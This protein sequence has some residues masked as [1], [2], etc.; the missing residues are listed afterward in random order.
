ICSMA[1]LGALQGCSLLDITS[2]KGA[3]AT[4]V[5]RNKP[6]EKSKTRQKSKSVASHK[7]GDAAKAEFATSQ[8]RLSEQVLSGRWTV[9]SVGGES[10]KGSDDDWP[11]MEFS[12]AD[13]RFY[14]S[15]GC[16]VINGSFAVESGQLISLTNMISTRRYCPEEEY[17]AGMSA[18]LA[19]TRSYSLEQ[20][21]NEYFLNFHNSKHITVLTL[22]K[23]NMDFVNGP[24]RVIE[25]EGERCDNGDVRMVVDIPE[26]RIHGQTGCNI[27]NGE[28]SE[29]PEKPNSIQFHGLVTTRMSCPDSSVETA[30]LVALEKVE[31][32]H[33]GGRN[34]VEL[35]D[36]QNQVVLRLQRIDDRR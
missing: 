2:R 16:N 7:S 17:A 10:V 23:H 28:L 33:P 9:Y 29:D 11:Y 5:V 35:L 15:D 13:N 20:R 25:I 12:V 34:V 4:E 30:F 32:A 14:G 36:K 1:M 27:L 31:T 21:G 18:A 22:R 26:G 19:D 6:D 8:I 3:T 24:W